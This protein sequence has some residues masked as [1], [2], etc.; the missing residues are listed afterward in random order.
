MERPI[1]PDSCQRIKP[2]ISKI[3]RLTKDIKVY[4]HTK[5]KACVILSPTP[6]I[7]ISSL[8]IDNIGGIGLEKKGEHKCTKSF[9]SPETY[10]KFQLENSKV[11]YTVMFLVDGKWKVHIIDRI[12]DSVYYNIQLY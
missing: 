9:L 11:Y 2:K 6:I 1:P 7:S 8:N 10:R 3:L 4:N 12:I 5:E